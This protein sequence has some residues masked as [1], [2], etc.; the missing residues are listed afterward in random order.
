MT[1]NNNI[2]E[3]KLIHDD[4]C[5]ESVLGT[6]LNIKNSINECRE[7]LDDNCFFNT[8]N[9]SIFKAIKEVDSRG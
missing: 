6:I 5:E 8:R 4:A 7:I 3:F 1:Q 9:K 2:T